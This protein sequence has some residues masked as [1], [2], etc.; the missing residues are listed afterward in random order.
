MAEAA[1]RYNLTYFIP[2]HG[3]LSCVTLSVAGRREQ[4]YS[5]DNVSI[6]A[7]HF[8]WG[9]WNELPQYQYTPLLHPVGLPESTRVGT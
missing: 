6:L 4:N 1:E 2:C 7:G 5:V 9:V 3:N 8:A